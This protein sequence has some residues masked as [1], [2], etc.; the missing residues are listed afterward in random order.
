ML[1]SCSVKLKQRI[2]ESLYIHPWRAKRL[3]KSIWATNFPGGS[4][5]PWLP[6]GIFQPRAE[7]TEIYPT[8]EA[9]YDRKHYLSERCC[10]VNIWYNYCAAGAAYLL[11]LRDPLYLHRCAA[12]TFSFD[13]VGSQYRACSREKHAVC[14]N[15]AVQRE[16]R[17]KRSGRSACDIAPFLANILN[18]SQLYGTPT[19]RHVLFVVKIPVAE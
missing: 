2:P 1:S 5:D 6:F 3:T 11:V 15:T 19:Q 17:K 9:Q 14:L 7:N 4:R 18:S 8:V 16:E 13:D 10:G 12:L